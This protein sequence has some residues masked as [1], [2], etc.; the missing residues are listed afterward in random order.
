M[1]QRMCMLL[2]GTTVYG[3]IVRAGVIGPVHFIL[4][5]G[6]DH[7]PQLQVCKHVCRFQG[8][9][10][11]WVFRLLFRGDAS[12][13]IIINAVVWFCMHVSGVSTYTVGHGTPIS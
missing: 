10:R 12:S 7:V 2:C 13:K 6:V 11:C 1:C 4:Y 9:V 5:G 3:S 8:K